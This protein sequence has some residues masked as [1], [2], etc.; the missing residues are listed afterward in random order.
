MPLKLNVG[1]SRKVGLPD[2]G[3]VGASC[4]LEV[5]LE[6]SLLERDPEA[7][8]GRV[9]DAYVAAHQAVHDE[10]ARLQAPSPAASSNGAGLAQHRSPV[11]GTRPAKPATTSQVRAIQSIA[12]RNGTDLAGLLQQEFDA[13]SPEDL[14]VAEASRLIDL[15]KST[16]AL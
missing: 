12:R 13:A 4:N 10:L 9:H 8:H 1:V 15:L 3:S 14:T 6:P 7:F 16:A 2:Y 5:E 11:Q